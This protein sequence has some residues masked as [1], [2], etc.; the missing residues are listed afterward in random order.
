MSQIILLYNTLK[1]WWNI[2][3]NIHNSRQQLTEMRPL[4]TDSDKQVFAIYLSYT[5]YTV[6]E[7]CYQ[8]C[9]L[10]LAVNIHAEA[11]HKYSL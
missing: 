1:E 9:I 4:S 7:S 10:R 5:M 3:N 8:G 11:D 6:N 2:R